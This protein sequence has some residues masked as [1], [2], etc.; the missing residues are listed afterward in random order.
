[1]DERE[2]LEQVPL[3]SGQY[4]IIPSVPDRP[5]AAWGC[6]VPPGTAQETPVTVPTSGIHKSGCGQHHEYS[7]DVKG[8]R[9]PPLQDACTGSGRKLR[10][11]SHPSP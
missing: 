7:T 11:A 3:E 6:W 9:F 5:V 4:A 2:V 8:H 1:M 10:A